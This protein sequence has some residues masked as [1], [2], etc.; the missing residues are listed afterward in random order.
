[1]VVELISI[2]NPLEKG[3]CSGCLFKETQYCTMPNSLQEYLEEM[4]GSCLKDEF[5]YVK[6]LEQRKQEAFKS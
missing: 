2:A 4:F 1:M 6:H 5:I 3:K